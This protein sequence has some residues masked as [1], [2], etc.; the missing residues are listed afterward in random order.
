MNY[1]KK[2]GIKF[3]YND[4]WIGGTYYYLNLIQVLKNID[5]SNQPI[6]VI[7]SKVKDFNYVAEHTKYQYLEF[8]DL[9]KNGISIYKKI[10]NRIYHAFFNRVYFKKKFT[11]QLDVLLLMKWNDYFINVSKENCVFWIPDFQHKYFPEFYSEQGMLKIEENMKWISLNARK[12]IFSSADA[13]NDWQKYYPNY[14]GKNQIIR[15]TVTHPEF[16]SI[17]SNTLRNKFS[18]FND[19]IMVPNQFWQHKNHFLVIQVAEYLKQIGKPQLFVF[20]GKENDDRNPDY[21]VNLKEYVKINKLDDVIKFLGFID[22]REQLKLMAESKAVLQPSKFEGWSTVIEDA[23]KLN[24]IILAS[25]LNVNKEQ[26]GPKGVFFE[27]NDYKDVSEKIL[28]LDIKQV[29]FNYDKKVSNFLDGILKIFEH[30]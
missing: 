18:I 26:L 12:V 25:N 5:T 19:F 15:F 10:I 9:E 21:V 17:D 6:I 11:G 29:E 13:L 1:R 20:C 14:T 27:M 16:D 8:I 2:L 7:F 28:N 22:R 30:D 4:Q 23:M 3:E 24:K